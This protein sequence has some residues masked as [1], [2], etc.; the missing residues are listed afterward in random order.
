LKS[1]PAVET[2]PS[3]GIKFNAVGDNEFPG[4][5]VLQVQKGEPKVVYPASEA[6]AKPIWPNPHFKK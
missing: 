3:Q 2:Y 5:V 1:G 4:V 6:E